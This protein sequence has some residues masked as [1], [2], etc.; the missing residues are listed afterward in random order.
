MEIAYPIYKKYTNVSL[1]CS[2]I[3]FYAWSYFTALFGFG[4]ATGLMLQNPFLFLFHISVWYK[5][6]FLYWNMFMNEQH[7]HIQQINPWLFYCF[8]PLVGLMFD[9][10]LLSSQQAPGAWRIKLTSCREMDFAVIMSK[11]IGGMADS[12]AFTW[13]FIL[14]I[15]SIMEWWKQMIINACDISEKL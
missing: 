2:S 15:L 8:V 7:R 12:Q 5:A 10:G 14:W 3:I 9:S 4:S 6:S 1:D 11:F 13:N